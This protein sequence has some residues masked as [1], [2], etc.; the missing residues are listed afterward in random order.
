[1]LLEAMMNGILQATM[2]ASV[3][4]RG[5]GGPA[6]MVPTFPLLYKMSGKLA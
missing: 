2:I 3:S 5:L 6:P 4:M 1:M